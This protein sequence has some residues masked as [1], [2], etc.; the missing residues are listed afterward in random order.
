MKRI[1]TLFILASLLLPDN[2]FYGNAW[3]AGADA[4]AAYHT[5]SRVAILMGADP[6]PNLSLAPDSNGFVDSNLGCDR[7]TTSGPNGGNQEA[8]ITAAQEMTCSAD[9]NTPGSGAY[10]RFCNCIRDLTTSGTS[11]LYTKISSGRF[12]QLEEQA[13]KAA[14]AIKVNSL[15]GPLR[16]IA[17]G[18]TYAAFNRSL[19]PTVAPMQSAEGVSTLPPARGGLAC[20][21]GNMG[22]YIEKLMT[23]GACNAKAIA[24]IN[25]GMSIVQEP[26]N[27]AAFASE[28]GDRN[29]GD[30][31]D[32]A[33]TRT[34]SEGVGLPYTDAGH[35]HAGFLQDARLLSDAPEDSTETDDAAASDT[36]SEAPSS[37]APPSEAVAT[38]TEDRRL[39]VILYEALMRGETAHIPESDYPKLKLNGL[40]ARY[41][42]NEDEEV[43]AEKITAFLAKLRAFVKEPNGAIPDRKKFMRKFHHDF[44]RS[45]LTKTLNECEEKILKPLK[46]KICPLIGENKFSIISLIG[47]LNT[48]AERKDFSE[49]MKKVGNASSAVQSDQLLCFAYSD[50]EASM[51]GIFNYTEGVPVSEPSEVFDI[52][53]DIPDD[54]VYNSPEHENNADRALIDGQRNQGNAIRNGEIIGGQIIIDLPHMQEVARQY[55]RRNNNVPNAKNADSDLKRLADGAPA[56]TTPVNNEG[57]NG[58]SNQ[59]LYG[60]NSGGN[61]NNLGGGS[62]ILPGGGGAGLE[63]SANA[64]G[65]GS[66][67]K[68]ASEGETVDYAGRIAELQRMIEDRERKL[69]EAMTRQNREVGDSL[70]SATRDRE[71]EVRG[72]KDEIKRLRDEMAS[73]RTQAAANGVTLPA[74]LAPTPVATPTAPVAKAPAAPG[75]VPG[76]APGS[77]G[78]APVARPGAFDGAA[79]PLAISSGDTLT[80]YDLYSSLG[81]VSNVNGMALT[82]N[83]V[84]FTP[85]AGQFII[86]RAEFDGADSTKRQQMY[87]LANGAP[88]YVVNAD[89]TVSVYVAQTDE[90]GVVAYVPDGSSAPVVAAKPKK[91][92]SRAPASVEGPVVDPTGTPEPEGRVRHQDLLKLMKGEGTSP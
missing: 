37:E 54:E 31:L 42:M 20:V 13:M 25:Q 8:I 59:N 73:A 65:S 69:R 80:G 19:R 10:G 40:I 2:P 29:F 91:K 67:K 46:E 23:D 43:K 79:P 49:L 14:V 52:P 4:G 55:N 11:D 90:E 75:A 33:Y 9:R 70:V 34:F 35:L 41:V 60:G 44:L 5:H 17:R 83:G 74:P 84:S 15:R 72:L 27:N 16:H 28:T 48:P 86:P 3:G 1:W 82:L 50:S 63:G 26:K 39:G 71:A 66:G 7:T 47:V 85:N 61:F 18:L 36:P 45:E 92:K 53:D 89:Q 64:A 6:G 51:N 56:N 62:A 22:N 78:P 88:I 12:A 32:R 21:P 38:M 24:R 30:V 58:K 76:S 81:F 77:A 68:G 87:A 57:A